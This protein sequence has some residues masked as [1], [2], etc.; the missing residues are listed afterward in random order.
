[1]V[2]KEKMISFLKSIHIDNVDDFDMH[3]EMVGRN[4][5][6]HEQIDM[7]IVKQTPW[8]YEFLH[9][10]QEGL[11]G[12]SYPYFVRFS[13]IKKPTSKDVAS[14]L[15]DWYQS[16][17]HIPF[18][19]EIETNKASITII[20]DD[21]M[22]KDL[23]SNTIFDFKDFLAFIN[24]DFM[25]E[26]QVKVHAPMVEEK[27][28]EKL[29]EQ[30]KVS[31]E[32]TEVE[33]IEEPEIE[34]PEIEETQIEVESSVEVEEENEEAKEI[35]ET[36]EATALIEKEKE[37]MQ[38]VT[39]DFYL[40]KMKE[41]LRELQNEKERQRLSKRGNYKLVEKIDDI[42]LESDHVDFVGKFFS[43]E[44]KEF[45]GKKKVILGVF[46]TAGGAIYVSQFINASFTEEILK[47]LSWGDNLRIRGV[48]KF[49]TFNKQL[50]IN[51]HYVDPLPPDEVEHEEGETR[52]E[53][54][55]HSNMS[56]M[57]GISNM[58]VYCKQAKLMGH[59]AIAP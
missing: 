54:H 6:K 53:L 36:D 49:D 5:F 59:K 37:A 29:V 26:E 55:L 38:E 19:Y 7:V 48:T 14:L 27:V 51:G 16:I 8:Q 1:M 34:E 41:N 31:E 30:E 44:E 11:N 2:T 43:K 58:D 35:K 47:K 52:V 9:Q 24:Y 40:E 12:V 25:V 33:V 4:R 23:C 32:K 18:P 15:K 50:T 28:S 21:E 46:D 13:Y 22:E 10:L 17:Y 39:E 56:A 45:G 3:F 57:D 20:F 42:T